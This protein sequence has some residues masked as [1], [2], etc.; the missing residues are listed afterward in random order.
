MDVATLLPVVLLRSSTGPTSCNDT[1][2]VDVVTVWPALH[3]RLLS[4]STGPT[5]CN[6]TW[7]PN[8]ATMLPVIYQRLLGVCTD[9]GPTNWNNTRAP[10]VATVLPVNRIDRDS[11]LGC[12]GGSSEFTRL[13]TALCPHRPVHILLNPLLCEHSVKCRSLKQPLD[14][15]SSFWARTKL[16]RS[17]I[18]SLLR[19]HRVASCPSTVMR[20][21]D[22]VSNGGVVHGL[23]DVEE[24]I[25]GAYILVGSPCH[26]RRTM[27]KGGNGQSVKGATQPIRRMLLCIHHRPSQSNGSRFCPLC[28]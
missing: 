15:P 19:F 24:T 10:N 5:S 2:A 11:L 12:L 27:N 14:V 21:R 17:S 16:P 26:F 1:R 6:D 28:R 20:S 23:A 25:S 7:A 3:W 9:T 13:V 22:C 18:Y 4:S 8:L